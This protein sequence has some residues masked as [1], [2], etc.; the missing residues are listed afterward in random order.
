M[1]LVFVGHPDT[2][3]IIVSDTISVFGGDVPTES[4]ILQGDPSEQILGTAEQIG[5]DLVIIGNKG[6]T[7]SR[8]ATFQSVPEKVLAGA[9]SDVLLCRTVHQR[10]SEMEP[11]EGGI[12]ERD[13]ERLA[14]YVDADGELHLMSAKCTHLGCVVAWNPAESTFDCPCHGSRFGP[15]GEVVEGPASKPL[16]PA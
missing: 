5:A 16:P 1:D 10:E 7:G 9:R 13:G 11:G 15:T 6:M 4:W 12:I 3:D 2:G 8:M 14:A